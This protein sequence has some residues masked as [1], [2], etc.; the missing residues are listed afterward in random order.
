MKK[1]IYIL[2]IGIL[3]Q[4]C[5]DNDDT[6][7][8]CG[9]DNPLLELAWLKTEIENRENN[10]TEDMKYC[11]ITQADYNGKTVFIYSDCNP[12]VNK[13]TP[14]YDCEGNWL[15]DSAENQI[16]FNDLQN[17]VII[18]KPDNFACQIN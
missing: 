9:V 3:L 5:T 10:P 8:A 7:A 2:L 13:I 1:S 6:S 17:S 4:S 11:Y 12:L 15:N 14:I 18:W 16:S